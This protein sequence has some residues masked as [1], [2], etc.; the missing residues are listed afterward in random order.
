VAVLFPCLPDSKH[1]TH[2]IAACTCQTC[3]DHTWCCPCTSTH[4]N[5]ILRKAYT[6]TNLHVLVLSGTLTPTTTTSSLSLRR[7]GV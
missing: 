2:P 5:H 7:G 6:H 4:S 3:D 1:H